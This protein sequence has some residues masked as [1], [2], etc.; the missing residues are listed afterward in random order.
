MP[1]GSPTHACTR[2]GVTVGRSQMPG[3]EPCLY[4]SIRS[5]LPPGLGLFFVPWNLPI[6]FFHVFSF[7]PWGLVPPSSLPGGVVGGVMGELMA[8]MLL[9][10]SSVSVASPLPVETMLLWAPALPREV[11]EWEV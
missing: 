9:P 7:L 10:V 2:A 11:C 3:T 1:G 4:S 5:D 6:I 8:L